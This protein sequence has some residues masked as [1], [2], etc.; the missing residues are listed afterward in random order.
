MVLIAALAS[1]LMFGAGCSSSNNANTTANTNANTDTANTAPATAP[2][3]DNSQIT[4]TN[5]NGVKT[6]TR[7]F[8]NNPRVSK[9]VV[10]TRD[11]NRTVKVYSP[12]G[13]ERE[14]KSE[15]EK[16][17]SAT[18][19][20]IADSVGFVKDKGSDVVDK[21][22]DTTSTVVDKTKEGTKTAIDKTKEGAETVKDKSTSTAK[23]VG[24]KT[25][26]GANTV[27]DKTKEGAKK[28]TNTAKK[29]IP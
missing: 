29:I 26:A 10:T 18:G 3:P 22:K 28:A 13:E 21:S 15:P 4:T 8:S 6:E 20:A 23:T 9:V 27:I 24:S 16:A 14:M 19:E 2:G 1:L 25:K 7:T 12:S 17:L 5:E 11:G